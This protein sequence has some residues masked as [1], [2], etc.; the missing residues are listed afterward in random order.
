MREYEVDCSPLSAVQKRIKVLC[1][2]DISKMADCRIY[3]SKDKT[4]EEKRNRFF[5]IPNAKTMLEVQVGNAIAAQHWYRPHSGQIQ[6]ELKDDSS[7]TTHWTA[8]RLI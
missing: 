8:S 7:I 3:R 4:G 6:L 5:Q 2:S 1:K